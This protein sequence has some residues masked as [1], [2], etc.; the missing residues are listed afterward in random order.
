MIDPGLTHLLAMFLGIIMGILIALPWRPL[1][2]RRIATRNIE[3]LS[4]QL[5]EAIAALEQQEKVRQPW[6]GGNLES[7]A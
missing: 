4:R 2:R 6:A 3:E 7:L 1:I 5:H